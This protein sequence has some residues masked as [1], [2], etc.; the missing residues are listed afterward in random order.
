MTSYNKTGWILLN[1]EHPRLDWEHARTDII[2]IFPCVSDI[3]AIAVKIRDAWRAR[4]NGSADSFPSAS[5][6]RRARGRGE[7]RALVQRFS[8]AQSASVARLQSVR[9]VR[10][11]CAVLRAYI[12]SSRLAWLDARLSARR[13]VYTRSHACEVSM[14]G[15]TSPIRFLVYP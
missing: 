12:I 9:C 11:R 6:G 13:W 2:W 8:V 7:L 3:S 5:G 14:T 4:S 15:Q 1:P 10:E